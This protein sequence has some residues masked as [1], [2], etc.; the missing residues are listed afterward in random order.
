MDACDAA[1]REGRSERLG[2]AVSTASP[3]FGIERFTALRLGQARYD[4][5]QRPQHAAQGH[6]AVDVERV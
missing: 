3:C 6:L 5:A 1:V 4:I 2:E